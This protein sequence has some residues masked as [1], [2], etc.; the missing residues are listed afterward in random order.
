M[1]FRI[2]LCFLLFFSRENYSLGQNYVFA[3]L[4][5]TPMNTTGWTFQGDAHVG[6]IT[7]TADS[8][9]VIC[10][11]NAVTQGSYLNLNPGSSGA[12]FYNQPINLSRCHQWTAEFDFRMFYGDG[13]DGIAFC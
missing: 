12:A 7:G 8:E 2:S 9:L 11:I 10:S 5:G 6:N 4:T 13:A 1:K 3:Q